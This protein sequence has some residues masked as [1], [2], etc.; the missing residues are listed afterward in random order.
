MTMKL[1]DRTRGALCILG[2][3]LCFSA[4]SVFVR[5]AG[6]LPVFEKAFFRNFVAAIVVFILIRIERVPLRI[7]KSSRLFVLLRC[8]FGT[9]GLVLNFYAIDRLNLADANMLNKLSPFFAI[10]FSALLLKERVRPLQAAAVAGAFLGSLLIIKPSG[11]N[12][13]LLPAIGGFFGGMG[14]GAAYTCLRR[15]T[16]SGVNSQLVV[17][18]FSCFSC[19]FTVPFIAAHFVPPTPTQLMLLILCGVFG[20]GGQFLITAAYTFAPA[21]EISVFDY[22]QVIFGAIFGLV[23]FDQMPDTL[24]FLGYAV[25]ILMA[26]MNF[27]YN[28]RIAAKNTDPIT[29]GESP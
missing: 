27:I 15:A 1:H 7:E 25:I 21:R 16:R 29:K 9:M 5:L 22:F 18:C 2:S 8:I 26:V 11:A 14:A 23:L 20:A 13:Q 17:L 19:L 28:N 24:S 12:L 6:D 4:M 3:A 10:I